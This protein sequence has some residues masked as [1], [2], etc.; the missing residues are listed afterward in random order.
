M[1]EVI[2]RY[3][4]GF[5]DYDIE[6]LSFS[7]PK[8]ESAVPLGQLT[9]GSFVL[10]S[11]G[12]RDFEAY[13]YSSDMRMVPRNNKV[14]GT[15][16]TI[17]YVFDSTG[18][19][20][21]DVIKGDIHVVSDAGEYYLPFVFNI[22]FGE[23][24]GSLGN[25]KNL[26]H[27]ANQ[28][29]ADWSEAVEL[30]Y[31]P[32]F[33][34]VFEGNDHVHYDK[35]RGFANIPGE[36]QSVDDFLVAV[37]KKHPIV[38]SVDRSVYEF[39]EVS[40]DLRCEI[41]LHKSTWGEVNVHITSDAEFITIA[42]GFVTGDKFIGNDHNLT[43]YIIDKALHEGRNYG[44]IHIESFH[45]SFDITIIARHRARVNDVRIERREKISLLNRLVKLYI[46]FRFKKINVNTW[47][48]ESMKIVERMNALDDKNPISRLYQAQLLLVQNRENEANWILE[49]VEKEMH[50]NEYGPQTYAYFWYLKALSSRSD[51][52]TS[53]V[54]QTVEE[55]FEKY[56][57]KFE[58]LWMLM[59]LDED[60]SRNSSRKI[61]LIEQ[62]YTGGCA[63]P[64][65]FIEAY[66]YYAMN[67][68]ELTKL[69]PFE[70]QVFNFALRNRIMDKEIATQLTYLAGRQRNFTLPLYRL[71]SA[72]YDMY[73]NDELVGVICTLLIKGSMTDNKYFRWFERA[74]QLQLRI[75]KLYEYYLYS[76]SADFDRML[77]QA[78]YM[79][80]G[81]RNDMDYHRIAFLYANLIKHRNE[82]SE[83]YETYRENMQIFAIEQIEKEHI[84]YNLATVYTDAVSPDFIRPDMAQ[85]LA[86]ILFSYAVKVDNDAVRVILIQN[87]FNVERSFP[88]DNG[89]AYPI[90]HSADY[91][92]LYEDREHRRRLVP[93][94][95]VTKLMNEAIYLPAVKSFVTD[96]VF[97]SLY[98]CEG[99]RHYVCVDDDNVD[100]CRELAESDVVRESY[101]RDIRMALLHYYY[102]NDR[103]S[104]LDDF[105]V[106]LDIKI[107]SERDRAEVIGFYARRGM[108][109]TAYQTMCIYGVQEVPA[110]VCVRI[111]NHMINHRDG[112]P[113]QQLIGFCYYAFANGKYDEVTLRY[114]A[115]HY[116]GLT[117]ELRNIWKAA[118]EFDLECYQLMERII[119]QMLY[120]HTTV[121]EKEEL[122]EMYVKAG[123]N[124]RVELAYLTNCS[125]EYF[126]RERITDER[127]FNQI[128]NNYRLGEELNEACK[129]ALLKYYAEEQTEYGDKIRNMLKEFLIDFL[130]RNTYFR[131]FENY[132]KLVPELTDYMDKTVIE[133]RTDPRSRVML[134]Y[135]LES[136]AQTG[137][138]SYH[139][140][141]MRNMFGGVFSREFVLFFGERLQYYITEE[142]DGKEM[143]TQSDSISVSDT[144]SGSAESRYSILN[145]MTVSQTVQDE[146]TLIKLIEEYARE[147][148]FAKNTFV[149]R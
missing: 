92:L 113:E 126:A 16:E 48:R 59:Y 54:A 115:D 36:A 15:T 75:T 97:F 17:N 133:Y 79:Y 98:L 27:F 28:A 57:D 110:K 22:T 25:V 66:N 73:H 14:N 65:L 132:K 78:V 51:K 120:T 85:H 148:A 136:S 143:L 149:M 20:P 39:N 58:L 61:D 46:D 101:K 70:I 93:Q 145:D 111:C 43:F 125:F 44:K 82:L 33:V 139:T 21:G 103:I 62:M 109:E 89:Y 40:D 42:D 119:I 140:E 128:V 7:V 68:A 74:V 146:S 32:E 123:A 56:P 45:Q 41:L 102:D 138:Q 34:H 26:F 135:V 137:E 19:E 141:E 1:R 116:E 134:H 114:L 23:I 81:F 142:R 91:I 77:P 99:R 69:S 117:K 24:R 108:F 18:L 37:N 72:L 94:N 122:F 29:Q 129:L 127:V 144:A 67:P 147:D 52:L 88:V 107:L 38:Y 131:F 55:L 96:N 5:F 95:A 112:V 83:M 49:H 64:I 76:I 12:G 50:V 47:V 60:L 130:H 86:E 10:Y 8:I 118:L 87:Q 4:D 124:T 30:F 6:R 90:I 35:Y 63:S 84:D 105:L 2:D 31:S 121:G 106:H 11:I 80:F 53:D 3:V 13:I 100:F 104:S 71:L 9:E